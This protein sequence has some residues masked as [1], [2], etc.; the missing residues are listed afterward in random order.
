MEGNWNKLIQSGSIQHRMVGID[1]LKAF[2]CLAILSWH[3]FANG[4][5]AINRIAAEQVIP[6]WNHLV[7]LFMLLSGFGI[8]NGYHKRFLKKEIQL[9]V[10]YKRRYQKIFPFFAVLVILNVI[11]D[12]SLN[13]IMEGLIEFS[14]VF[15][16]LPN[17]MLNVL[18]IAWT[19][20]VIF[21]FYITYPFFVFLTADGKRSWLAFFCSVIIQG[22][23][24][25]YFMTGTFVAENYVPKHS[26]LY[27][28]PFFLAGCIIYL[29]R[30]QLVLFT[31][32]K[33]CMTLVICLISTV[34]FYLVPHKIGDFSTLEFLLLWL[35]TA[36][37]VFSLTIQEIP[38]VEGLVRYI[39]GISM[40]I[41]LSHMLC[42][43]IVEKTGI[44]ALFGKGGVAYIVTV[45]L[46]LVAVMIFIP[47]V[48][49]FLKLTKSVFSKV[50]V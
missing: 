2:S 32:R 27:C 31:G 45:L 19:L 29:Y 42:Y 37:T 18:G 8:S 16:F 38:G 14:L 25:N 43:R 41:Y 10:F 48:Q 20:G 3:V 5:F 23:C 1:L 33:K 9:E 17:N 12:L 28:V 30:D 44:V 46:T 22:M 13:S 24:Q 39:S 50:S 11:A 47:V 21:V 36:W 15:G 6:S 40:E 35:Y 26:F 34:V 7:Y 4:D 49:Y